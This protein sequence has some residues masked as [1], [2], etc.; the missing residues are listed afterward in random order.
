MGRISDKAITSDCGFL[1]QVP[2]YSIIMA[3]KGFNISQ[4]CAARQISLYVPPGK[5]GESQ[6]TSAAVLKTKKIAN[7]RILIEQV[8]RWLKNFC[9][10]KYEV[11]ITLVGHID[12]MVTVCFT[13]CNLRDPIYKT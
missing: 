6:M 11:P 5:H 4:E 2:P 13:L 12:Q 3:D 9:V 8:I 1:E 10:L 7:L